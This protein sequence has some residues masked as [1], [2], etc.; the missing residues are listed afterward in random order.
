ML[1]IV[2]GQDGGVDLSAELTPGQRD[3][4]LTTVQGLLDDPCAQA[5]G[6]TAL[7]I[8]KLG[9]VC[10]VVLPPIVKKDLVWITPDA[11]ARHP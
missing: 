2:R 5:P 9:G 11:P 3:E 7:P 1:E 6:A 4:I 10:R 8:A